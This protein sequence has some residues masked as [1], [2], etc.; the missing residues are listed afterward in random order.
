MTKTIDLRN[1]LTIMILK[2][3]YYS[4]IFFPLI[5]FSIRRIDNRRFVINLFSLY[6][7]L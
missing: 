5:L 4:E 6:I 2:S 7:D 3:L 1:L